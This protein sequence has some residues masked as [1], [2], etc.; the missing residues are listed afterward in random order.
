MFLG[1]ST[2]ASAETA[3]GLQALKNKDYA[4]A[5][6]EFK[7]GVDR[8]EADAQ[9]NLGLMYARGLGVEKDIPLA[10]DLFSGQRRERGSAV[11]AGVR[12]AQGWGV[13]QDFAEASKWYLLSA[14]QGDTYAEN[15][16]ASL[17]EDGFGVEQDYNMA[18]HYYMLAAKSGFAPAQ[19]NLAQLIEKG[20]GVKRDSGSVQV[21]SEG[22]ADRGMASAQAKVSDMF[23]A[24]GRG[25]RQ[26]RRR[27]ISGR[28]SQRSR[29]KRTL[30]EERRRYRHS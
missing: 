2:V 26:T 15:G 30:S 3:V 17:Y 8:G 11:P 12:S 28:R 5:V 4:T 6:R 16:I 7:A 1:I 24:R 14:N 20:K 21:V 19:F 27:L 18:V 22:T 25:V 10:W 13:Q 23:G 29:T 9:F